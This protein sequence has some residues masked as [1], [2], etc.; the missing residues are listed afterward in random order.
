MRFTFDM[1]VCRAEGA[2]C[3][4][5]WRRCNRRTVA[6][7]ASW[8]LPKLLSNYL[9]FYPVSSLMV[10]N[11]HLWHSL[12]ANRFTASSNRRPVF[13]SAK[14]I[15][16]IFY[17]RHCEWDFNLNHTSHQRSDLLGESTK[18]RIRFTSSTVNQSDSLD[19]TAA[20]NSRET[21]KRNLPSSFH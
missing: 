13:N 8:L 1:I 21:V 14:W 17:Q 10:I 15:S 4:P 7:A 5:I 20:V 3:R 6:K 19:T 2:I 16:Y 11:C 18:Q 9:A 12:F